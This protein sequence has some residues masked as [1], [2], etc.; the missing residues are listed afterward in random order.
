VASSRCEP[1]TVSRFLAWEDLQ[2]GTHEFDGIRIIEV[3]G[4]SRA[5][6]GIVAA[7]P[8]LLEDPLD[9]DRLDAGQEM[10]VHAGGTIHYP[11]IAVITAPVAE[12]S[13]TL[14]DAAVWFEVPSENT[15]QTDLGPKL[16][17]Y[18]R[19]RSVRRCLTIEHGR[20]GSLRTNGPNRAGWR[21]IL[22]AAAPIFPRAEFRRCW[23]R[24]IGGLGR[25][26]FTARPAGGVP[27]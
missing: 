5:H 23:R 12:A 21:P 10:R 1:W 27:V 11:D 15:A 3:A 16:V 19:L 22:G 6:E 2:D 18:A 7:L 25:R 20:M 17:E 9:P 14:L 4:G 13:R 26:Y 8:H 24:S